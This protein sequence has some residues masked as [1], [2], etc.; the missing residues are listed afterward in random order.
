M[1]VIF[2]LWAGFYFDVIF[3][4]LVFN[5]GLNNILVVVGLDLFKTHKL[6]AEL[7]SILNTHN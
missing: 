2:L 5:F 3:S 1:V 4:L 7:S 6:V